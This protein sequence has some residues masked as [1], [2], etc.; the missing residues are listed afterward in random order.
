MLRRTCRD[1]V[2]GYLLPRLL[3]ELPRRLFRGTRRRHL[4][5]AHDLVRLRLPEPLEIDGLD[6]ARQR[7][8]PRF[9]AMIVDLAEL[10]RV[11]SELA[12]HLDMRLR[13]AVSLLRLDPGLEIIRNGRR[14]LAHGRILRCGRTTHNRDSRKR[15]GSGAISPLFHARREPS[16]RAPGEKSITCGS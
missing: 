6:E 11:H 9:L 1:I 14:L 8:L 10:P 7:R 5:E 16:L 15:Y 4:H 3:G 12:R 13:E 2:G